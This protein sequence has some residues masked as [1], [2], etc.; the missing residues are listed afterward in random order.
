MHVKTAPNLHCVNKGYNTILLVNSDAET[1]SDKTCKHI[2]LYKPLH[3]VKSPLIGIILLKKYHFISTW[4]EKHN[5]K[6]TSRLMDF[7]TR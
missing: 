7:T 6:V 2:K 5:R 1:Q 4:Q 3:F